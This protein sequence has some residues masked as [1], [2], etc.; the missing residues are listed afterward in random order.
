MD[1]IKIYYEYNDCNN[2][3]HK[4][5]LDI[6]KTYYHDATAVNPLYDYKF[7]ILITQKLTDDFIT[8]ILIWIEN[9]NYYINGYIPLKLNFYSENNDNKNYINITFI[10]NISN[11]KY[12]TPYIQFINIDYNFTY[13]NELYENNI[14]IPI[15]YRIVPNNPTIQDYFIPCPLTFKEIQNQIVPYIL[16]HKYLK[17]NNQE[18][19][20]NFQLN[21]TKKELNQI[22]YNYSEV[23][24]KF[25]IYNDKNHKEILDKNQELIQRI[26]TLENNTSEISKIEI[27]NI[28][29]NI[30]KLIENCNKNNLTF[31][32]R[33][34][35]LAK[36]VKSNTEIQ[37]NITND[38]NTFTKNR[39]KYNM[40]LHGLNDKIKSIETY[41][42]RMNIINI[43]IIIFMGIFYYL[44]LFK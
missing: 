7:K 4:K 33:L 20:N 9:N 25:M 13:K 27:D 42:K 29:K 35:T 2:K 34:Q 11:N 28:N 17:D 39:H 26:E 3:N 36:F 44:F 40:V 32:S 14:N 6:D 10:T 41:N 8:N 12:S 5:Y 18:L 21:E 31:N 24:K 43:I 30:V 22:L 16:Y 37:N 38:V 1:K 23:I 19:I 15:N